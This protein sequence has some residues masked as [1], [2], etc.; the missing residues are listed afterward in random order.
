MIHTYILHINYINIDLVWEDFDN[1]YELIS[2]YSSLENSCTLQ[3]SRLNALFAI[4]E[5]VWVVEMCTTCR[6]KAYFA[7]LLEIL[8]PL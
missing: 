6:F 8:N 4:L 1:F 3:I 2:F 5:C 7:N